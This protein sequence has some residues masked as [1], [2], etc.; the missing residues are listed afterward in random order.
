MVHFYLKDTI[1]ILKVFRPLSRV[2]FFLS[3]APTKALILGTGGASRAVQFA[4]RSH[5][6]G[7]TLVS[8]KISKDSQVNYS[9][10]T[11]DDLKHY[12]LIINT[13]PLGMFPDI[14][15]KP[16]IRYAGIGA[17]HVLIDL[18]YNPAETA[19]FWK[20]EKKR[21]ATVFNGM[22]MFT[23]QAEQAWKIWQE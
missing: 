3:K 4:L 16:R 22:Q 20:K 2:L 17:E 23:E 15:S 9:M 6:I 13:T 7:F 14:H 11:A 21:G 19:F 8:R 10:L 5:G 12:P 18:I 1:R